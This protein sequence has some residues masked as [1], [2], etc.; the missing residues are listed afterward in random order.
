MYVCAIKIFLIFYGLKELHFGRNEGT[1][2]VFSEA[3][4]VPQL[5][6]AFI[7]FR[8]LEGDSCAT[9]LRDFPGQMMNEPRGVIEDRTCEG[10]EDVY[11]LNMTVKI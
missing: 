9:S 6:C 8:S 5:P 3:R 7:H 4:Q 10:K 11:C 2:Y 1:D